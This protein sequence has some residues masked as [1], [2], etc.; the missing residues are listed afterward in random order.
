M[1][2]ALTSVFALLTCVEAAAETTNRPEIWRGENGFRVVDG[3]ARFAKASVAPGGVLFEYALA[4][5]RTGVMSSD[6][7]LTHGTQTVTI[8][9]GAVF[10]AKEILPSPPAPNEKIE[11]RPKND[12]HW[13]AAEASGPAVCFRG[14]PDGSAEMSWSTM[15]YPPLN[16][17]PFLAWIQ[18]GAIP[19]S[20]Q[21]VN[22]GPL[23]V[24]CILTS[25]NESGAMTNVIDSQG[26]EVYSSSYL[27]RFDQIIYGWNDK[28]GVFTDGLKIEPVRSQAG[29]IIGAKVVP[30]GRY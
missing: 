7:I 29:E 1:R 24:R 3:S 17:V 28:D 21:P 8:P 27:I 11:P 23:V 2:I 13:C 5:K 18:A 25:I 22:V 6:F 9:K 26:A 4:P 15:L 19:L 16:R 10:V 20:E 12:V 14:A 30:V